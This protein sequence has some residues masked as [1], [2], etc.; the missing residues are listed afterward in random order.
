MLQDQ[1]RR[2]RPAGDITVNTAAEDVTLQFLEMKPGD[3]EK[4]HVP[5]FKF[6]IVLGNSVDVGYINF[7]I[8]D[9]DHIKY[10]AGH[11]GYEINEAHRGHSYSYYACIA[12]APIIRPIYNS[13]LIT[14]DPENRASIRIIEKLGCEFIDEINIDKNEIGYQN[15]ERRKKRYRWFPPD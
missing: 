2:T 5:Y 13:V 1:D 7:R 8:G 15:G 9:T 6:K 4:G 3:R 11:I 10:Y 12:L 14:S